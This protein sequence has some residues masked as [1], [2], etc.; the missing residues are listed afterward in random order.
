MSQPTIT[1]GGPEYISR[2][3]DLYGV[4]FRD[5]P[6][7]VFMLQ[8]L[9]REK[10]HAYMRA[11]YMALMTQ[12]GLNGAIFDE[13]GD[14]LSCSVLMPPGTAIDNPWTMLSAG[15]LGLLWNVG[16]GG[17][18]RMLAVY[19]PLSKAA[20]A[21]VIKKDQKHYYV[22][23]LGTSEEARGGGLGSALVKKCQQR[24]AAEEVPVWLEAT[25]EGS[26]RLYSRLGFETVEKFWLGKG[27]VNEKGE[28]QISGSGVPV[29]GMIWWSEKRKAR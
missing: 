21:R 16:I 6:V 1:S 27:T 12:A 18:Y 17:C 9:V 28:R 2:T 14:Y 22:F 8:S 5:D 7:I 23:H 29:W 20:K 25:T 11:Y 24:A 10:R 3:A 26:W 13:A 15:I 4:V 19:E